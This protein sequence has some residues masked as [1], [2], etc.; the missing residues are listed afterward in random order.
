LLYTVKKQ[1]QQ[2]TLSFLK[3]RARISWAKPLNNEQVDQKSLRVAT[4][5]PPIRNRNMN[6][7]FFAQA[8][9][10]HGISHCF[11]TV[12]RRCEHQ[13]QGPQDHLIEG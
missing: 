7:Q 8:G 6:P 5:R 3:R 10:N 12:H 2:P 11:N 9:S 13:R 4:S 1:S